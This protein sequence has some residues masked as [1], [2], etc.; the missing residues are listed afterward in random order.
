MFRADFFRFA[1]KLVQI[2]PYLLPPPGQWAGQ[3]LVLQPVRHEPARIRDRL[4]NCPERPHLA[5]SRSCQQAGRG[6]GRSRELV[7][8][9]VHHVL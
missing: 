7:L 6:Q 4:C 5:L 1:S 9:S 2:S 8:L 3:D